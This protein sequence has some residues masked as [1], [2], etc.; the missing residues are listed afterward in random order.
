MMVS[1]DGCR[2]EHDPLATP[3][4]FHVFMER[5]VQVIYCHDCADIWSA[6]EAAHEAMAARFNKLLDAW[7][8]TERAKLPLKFTPLDYPALAATPTGALRLG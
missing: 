1:C 4:P 5:G 3:R 2:N 6:F 7:D 8:E